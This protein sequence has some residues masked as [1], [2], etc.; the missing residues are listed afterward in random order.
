MKVTFTP[1]V[2]PDH[3]VPKGALPNQPGAQACWYFYLLAQK[4]KE[5]V[6]NSTEDQFG[7]VDGDLWMDKH[8]VQL[9]RSIAMQYGLDSPDE[10]AKFWNEVKQEAYLCGLPIPAEEYTRL[11]P[12]VIIQ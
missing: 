4:I 11:A 7:L 2:F 3:T 12:G 5:R 1:I 6:G 10:F 8:Y 9:A